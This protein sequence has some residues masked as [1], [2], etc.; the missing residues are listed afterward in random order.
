MESVQEGPET[1]ASMRADIRRYE[2]AQR[3]RATIRR[4]VVFV[5]FIVGLSLMYTGYKAVGQSI[6]DAQRDWPVIGSVMPATN[7]LIMPRIAAI[8]SE[9]DDPPQ[10]RN[11]KTL[12]GFI[13]EAS[14]FTAREAFFGFVA[15]VVLGM[16]L[17][18]LMLRSRSIERGLMPYVVVSQT[19]P[20]VAIAPIIVI[21]GRTNFDWLPFTWQNWMSVSIIATYLTFFP[22]AV[23]GLKGLQSP[24]SEAI[25]LMDSYAS[26]RTQTLLK[27]RLPASVPYLFAAFKLA[28]SAS[29]VGAI[30]GEIS[31]G[32]SGGLGRR[33]LLQALSYTTA[34]ARLYAAVIGSAL[35][36]IFVFLV[37]TGT[38]KL[39]LGRQGREAVT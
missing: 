8:I 30:V 33:I 36:G 5:V 22:V 21:W 15:G 20:L 38:E 13:F 19:V 24:S 31:A 32:V 25:E 37:I 12:G 3:F 14:L 34:P 23:N 29:I 11:S 10:R 1:A 9:F 17:A 6:D 39:V 26:S 7:D 4:V 28:A 16:G 27:L 18:I 2:R 35:L